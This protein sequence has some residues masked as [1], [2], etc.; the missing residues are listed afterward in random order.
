MSKKLDQIILFFIL[1]ICISNSNPPENFEFN[2]STIQAF[3]FIKKVEV[4]GLQLN[5]KDW[6]A[7]FNGDICTGTRQWT[8]EF[9]DIPAMGYDGS[10]YT[11]GYHLPGSKPIFKIY[12]YSSGKIFVA[13]PDTNI[14]F[15][16]SPAQIININKLSVNRDCLGV[17]GGLAK[18]DSC[19]VCN[20]DNSTCNKVNN[21]IQY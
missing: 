9:T 6:I 1:N 10:Q 13:T 15:G 5:E 17:L 2:Q 12:D 16:N 21:Q 7:S 8:G 20:G 4:D 3:Y 14:F 19:N 18:V 11:K